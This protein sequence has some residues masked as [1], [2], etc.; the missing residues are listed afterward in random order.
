MF[1]HGICH[2][3]AFLGINGLHPAGYPGGNITADM[4]PFRS[5]NLIVQLIN[6]LLQLGH[7]RADGSHIH[8]YQQVTL[9]N[10]VSEGRQNFRGLH[11]LR[12][13]DDFRIHIFQRSG[14]GYHR[15]DGAPLRCCAHYFCIGYGKLLPHPPAQNQN[16]RCQD[17]NADH[18]CQYHRSDGLAAALLFRFAQGVKQGFV[19]LL[20]CIPLL[21]KNILILI[22]HGYSFP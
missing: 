16:C 9:G 2:R 12:Q 11:P 6:F 7:C 18:R 13:R 3:R 1:C 8:R 4:V 15:A 14:T 19:L 5:G 21:G 10:G 22:V 20:F 17:H